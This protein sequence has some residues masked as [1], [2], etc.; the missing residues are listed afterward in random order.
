MSNSKINTLKIFKILE[1]VLNELEADEYEGLINEMG[2]L[3]YQ[4]IGKSEISNVVKRNEGSNS[5]NPNIDE[6]VQKLGDAKTKE[7]GNEILSLK[8]KKVVLLDVAGAFSVH[9][10]KNDTKETI[11]FKI[12]E[13]VI[14]AKLRSEAI[15]QTELRRRNKLEP[16]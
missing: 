7:E 3:V 5:P 13:S 8:L 10:R 12:I 1:K 4:P 9:V 6:I 16:T 15:K 11:I 14:G 2:Q